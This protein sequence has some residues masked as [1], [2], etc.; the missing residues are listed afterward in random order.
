FHQYRLLF[1]SFFSEFAT[2]EYRRKNMNYVKCI[3]S[4]G[5]ES[6]VELNGIYTVVSDSEKDATGFIHIL[7]KNGETASIPAFR[8]IYLNKKEEQAA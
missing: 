7:D 3:N 6:S 8:F 5:Y 4:L 2:I 1:V